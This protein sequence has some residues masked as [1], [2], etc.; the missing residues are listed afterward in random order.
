MVT[1]F[2]VSAD[3]IR[4]RLAGDFRGWKRNHSKFEAQVRNVIRALRADDAAREILP[5][6]KL[7]ASPWYAIREI[8]VA[9]RTRSFPSGSSPRSLDSGMARIMIAFR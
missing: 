3:W 2:K 7:Q 1:I 6:A 8:S 4:E 5:T 9:C